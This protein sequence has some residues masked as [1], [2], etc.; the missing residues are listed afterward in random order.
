MT[1]EQSAGARITAEATSWPGVHAEYGTRGELAFR[2]GPR[3]IGHIHGD[4]AAHYTFPKA[5]WHELYAAGR[6][7]HHPVFPGRVGPA[8]RRIDGEEDMVDAITLLRLNYERI[9]ARHGVAA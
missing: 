2:V 8:A 1:T 4:H 9:V 3:E 5:V 7:V 6:I